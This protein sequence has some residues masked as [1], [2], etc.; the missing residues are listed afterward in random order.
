MRHTRWHAH[1][2]WRILPTGAAKG[3]RS[4]SPFP[5]STHRNEAI[6]L[7]HPT[8]PKLAKKSLTLT[9]T[10]PHTPQ[11]G[12]AGDVPSNAELTEMPLNGRNFSD[13]AYLTGSV[14]PCG[15]GTDDQFASRYP[16]TLGANLR[17]RKAVITAAG[18]TQRALPLQTL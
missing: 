9:P 3:R 14:I 6:Y 10:P 12:A 11:R 8:P 2:H 5:H 13:L 4:D 17:V 16:A 7:L 18:Q 15:E 1:F